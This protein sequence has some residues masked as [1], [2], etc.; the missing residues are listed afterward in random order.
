MLSVDNTVPA[1]FNKFYDRKEQGIVADYVVIM[2]Y[3]EH[4]N[5][6]APARWRPW[7]TCGTGLRIP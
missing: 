7:D 2:G 4:Y 6:G 5:G 1:E 3:D